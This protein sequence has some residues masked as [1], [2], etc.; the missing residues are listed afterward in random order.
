MKTKEGNTMKN[1]HTI[2]VKLEGSEWTK[3]LDDTFKKKNSEVTIDGFRKGKAPKDRFIKKFGIESLY[4][5]SIDA[6]L[7]VAYEKGLKDKD[8]TPVCEPKV[9]VKDIDEDHVELEFTVITK[10]EVKISGYK[11]L[12]VKKEVPKVTKK[13]I[14]EEL[15]RMRGRFAEMVVK[16]TGKVEK[17]D[18]AVIDF[19]GYVDGEAFEGGEGTD[20]PLERQRSRS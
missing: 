8:L 9:D 10:P 3:I 20:Y 17:G 18:V 4:M 7:P 14:E 16:E 12:G 6:A 15:E 11:K 1:V 13:E 2:S 19:K 5:D